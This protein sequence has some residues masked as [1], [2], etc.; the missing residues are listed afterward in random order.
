[1]S[2]FSVDKGA[3]DSSAHNVSCWPGDI[4]SQSCS[5]TVRVPSKTTI[6]RPQSLCKLP[7]SCGYKC[8]AEGLGHTS[9][10]A[11][12]SCKAYTN[13]AVHSADMYSTAFLVCSLPIRQN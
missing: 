11:L 3:K 4:F 2:S 12:L 7:F 8:S 6:C 9:Q 10:I 5:R 1:M 13:S